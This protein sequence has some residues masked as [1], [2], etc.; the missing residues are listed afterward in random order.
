MFEMFRLRRSIQDYRHLVLANDAG[1]LDGMVTVAG[2]AGILVPL[3]FCRELVADARLAP[4]WESLAIKRHA[5]F[6]V[7][8][9]LLSKL[10]QRFNYTVERMGINPFTDSMDRALTDEHPDLFELCKHTSRD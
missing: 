1:S 5:C 9:L 4:V 10:F 3:V 7:D 8:Y 2:Y 6:N